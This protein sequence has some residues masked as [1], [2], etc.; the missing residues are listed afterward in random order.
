MASAWGA[1]WGLAWGASWGSPADTH[2][3]GDDTD[4]RKRADAAR[5]EA[6]RKKRE[7]REQLRADIRLALLGPEAEEIR[8]ELTPYAAPSEAAPFY[9]TVDV[10]A[11]AERISK[12]VATAEA[13]QR[14][15][16]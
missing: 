1:S 5:D 16:H 8:E 4:S 10:E 6:D 9:E 15:A 12:L 2:D 11:V 3:G 14:I 7:A 13:I